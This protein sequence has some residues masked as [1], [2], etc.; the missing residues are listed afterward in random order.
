MRKTQWRSNDEQ[1]LLDRGERVAV[2]DQ[3]IYVALYVGGLYSID[4]HLR[5]SV[6]VQQ[7]SLTL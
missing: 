2:R 3:L 7:G 4:P 5:K 6:L 1:L